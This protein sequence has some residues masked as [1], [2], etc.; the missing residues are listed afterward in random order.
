MKNKMLILNLAML[1]WVLL[2]STVLGFPDTK[3]LGF[4]V[5]VVVLMN[6]SIYADEQKKIARKPL[7]KKRKTRK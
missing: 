2:L 1:A 3:S 7:P 5:I 4:L 6:V